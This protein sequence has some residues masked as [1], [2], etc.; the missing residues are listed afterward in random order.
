MRDAR[1]AGVGVVAD[2]VKADRIE[3]RG[4]RQYVEVVA[5]IAQAVLVAWYGHIVESADVQVVIRRRGV[6]VGQGGRYACLDVVNVK[7]H[8]RSGK[9]GGD[10]VPRTKAESVRS[11]H[12]ASP[13]LFDLKP[14][15][16]GSI[17]EKTPGVICVV[18]F[19][20]YR[21]LCCRCPCYAVVVDCCIIY[22]CGKALGVYTE[23]EA[24]A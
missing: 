2:R 16:A 1:S 6:A 24:K 15:I 5:R 8:S 11:A 20:R 13:G 18:C 22:L 17:D 4:P 3:W 21:V 23:A 9:D 7:Q 10:V 12:V 19:G 14:E